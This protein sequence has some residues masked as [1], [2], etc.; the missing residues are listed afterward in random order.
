MHSAVVL[1]PPSTANSSQVRTSFYRIAA[2]LAGVTLTKPEIDVTSKV[3]W[4]QGIAGATMQCNSE[5]SYDRS[6][7]LR[8]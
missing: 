2:D 5:H 7:L 3:T 1:F 4:L 6:W 8:L